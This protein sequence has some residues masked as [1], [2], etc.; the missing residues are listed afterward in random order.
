MWYQ[1]APWP[2][3]NRRWQ[4]S[5]IEIGGDGTYQILLSVEDTLDAWKLNHVYGDH[6]MRDNLPVTQ[7]EYPLDDST[8]I[9]YRTDLGGRLT[10]FNGQFVDAAR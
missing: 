2:D 1:A 9:V 7:N 5:N 10:Y 3:T 4:I 6:L 8:L